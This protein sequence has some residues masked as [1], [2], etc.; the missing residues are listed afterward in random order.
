MI[1]NNKFLTL[2]VFLIFVTSEALAVTRNFDGSK[3]D[4][5]GKLIKGPSYLDFQKA[6]NDYWNSLYPIEGEEVP[7]TQRRS[8]LKI[9]MCRQLRT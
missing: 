8:S 6:L 9:Q 4:V 7:K 1:I 2:I 3:T 5:N